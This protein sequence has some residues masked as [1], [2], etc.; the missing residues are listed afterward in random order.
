MFG[1]EKFSWGRK[2]KWGNF[3]GSVWRKN[4]FGFYFEGFQFKLGI[5]CFAVVFVTFMERF[6]RKLS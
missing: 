3:W 1:E 2:V 4:R 6:F 5:I